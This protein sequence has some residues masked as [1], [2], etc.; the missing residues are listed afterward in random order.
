MKKVLIRLIIIILIIIGIAVFSVNKINDTKIDYQI[1]EVNSYQYLQY[2]DNGKYGVID[3]QGNIIISAEY[4]KVVIPNPE[5]DIFVCYEKNENTKIFNSNGE[6]IFTKYDKVEPI[7]L[8]N[9]ASVLCYEKSTLKYEKDG[10]YGLIDFQGK[11][12]TKN[13]YN[14]IENL[15]GVEGKLLVS[16]DNK[17][18]VI[19]I[20]GKELVKT[21]YD[22]IKSDGYYFEKENNVKTGYIV[23]NTTD[24]GY[25]YGYINYR[26]KKLLDTKYNEIIRI[27][28]IEGI[29]L[30]ASD[31]GKYGLYQDSNNIIKHEYQ[32]IIYNDIGLLMLEKNKQYGMSDLKGNIKVEIQYTDIEIRGIYIYASKLNENSVFDTNGNKIDINFNKSLYETGNENYRISTIVNNNITYY[33]IEDKEGKNLVSESYEFIEY[34]YGDYFIAKNKD[35]KSG[36]ID[37]SGKVMMDFKYD[38]VQTIKNK[39]MIQTLNSKTN[40]T[41]I[42]S[43]NLKVICKMKNARIDNEDNYIKVYNNELERYFDNQ[44]NEIEPDEE[45]IKETVS[46]ELPATI[47][48]YVKTQYSLDNAYYMKK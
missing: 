47:G 24:D 13:I 4:E 12:I 15:Q 36:I 9:I 19:N 2:S 44:G 27:S 3:K 5:K 32:S 48:D 35:G 45:I 42:Y 6:T 10:K 39:N 18:G 21:K 34:A 23:S 7:K 25:K 38:L 26:G 28:D 17:F 20:K 43:P 37:Y 46:K 16:K 1:S 22:N 41:Q 31:N 30:I 8:K 33:G 29:Y 40:Q 14:S 11:E